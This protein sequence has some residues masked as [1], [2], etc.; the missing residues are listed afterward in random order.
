MGELKDRDW[1]DRALSQYPYT[2][3]VEANPFEG[4]WRE[5]ASRIAPRLNVVD[6]G[7][8][9]GH[10]ASLVAPTSA[11]Y[12]GIDWSPA[13]ID[14]ARRALKF[15]PA[16]FV[17]GDVTKFWPTI[18]ADIYVACEFLEHV[19]DDLAILRRIP[20]GKSLLASLPKKDSESHVRVF[21]TEESVWRRYDRMFIIAEVTEFEDWWIVKGVRR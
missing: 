5:L 16:F 18:T 19:E 14:V 2:A 6:L 11:S 9:P 1:Y 13:A 8:G 21:S 10:L 20:A 12:F 4:L 15:A 17:C 7:C 3:P